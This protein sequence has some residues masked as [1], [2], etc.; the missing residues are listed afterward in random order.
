MNLQVI[1]DLFLEKILGE[2]YDMNGVI[3][4][5]FVFMIVVIIVRRNKKK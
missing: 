4:L 3:V 5:M 2:G 1:I